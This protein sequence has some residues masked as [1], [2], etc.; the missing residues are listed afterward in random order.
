MNAIE[1]SHL[2]RTFKT[3]IGLFK[4]QTKLVEAVK[5]VSFDVK[6]GELFG[7]LGPNGAGKTTTVKM[8]TTLS[9][10]RSALFKRRANFLTGCPI[11]YDPKIRG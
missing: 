7:L 1:V 4:R 6:P 11:L 2:K 8:L 9:I 5:D 10:I 3:N